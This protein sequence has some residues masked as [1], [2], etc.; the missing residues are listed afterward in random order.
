M[1]KDTVMQLLVDFNMAEEDGRIPALLPP[2]QELFA[3]SEVIATDGEGT[4]RRAVIDEVAS[5]GR[6]LMLKPIDGSGTVFNTAS[7]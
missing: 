7:S 2:G 6:Y 4:E 3:G 5:N 1:A